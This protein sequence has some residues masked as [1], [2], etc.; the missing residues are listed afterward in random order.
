MNSLKLK[1][2][3]LACA[4]MNTAN[5]FTNTNN[6]KKSEKKSVEIEKTV[7]DKNESSDDKNGNKA[8]KNVENETEE[9]IEEEAKSPTK[10]SQR[11]DN[12]IDIKALVHEET[13]DYRIVN[14]NNVR[15]ILKTKNND[16]YSAKIVYSGGE[17]M[18]RSIGNYGGNEIFA[19]EIPNT[20]REYYFKLVDGKVKYF[21]GK[22]TTTSESS[23]QKFQYK[24]S[25]KLT[26][27]PEWAR[28][29]VGYQ[30]YIDSF[31]NGNVD[32]DPIFN[33][34]GTDDFAPPEGEIRSGT[35]KK[36]LVTAEWGTTPYSFSV[37]EWNG[38]YET[39]NEWEENA[40]ND[41]QNYTRYYGGDLQWNIL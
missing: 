32:N 17:K 38:N 33:E 15:L 18:M 22:N 29:S 13:P 34:F 35:R 31:R 30:I 2:V 24:K 41:V 9:K 12:S 10:Y 28:G 39:K 19:A 25:E 20:V 16:V 36:D 40:L 27:I 26:Y 21:Y 7:S 11:D 4:M 8:S 37:N 1:L 5:S 6:S 14:G 23:V 3:I